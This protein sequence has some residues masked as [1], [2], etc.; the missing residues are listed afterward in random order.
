[1]AQAASQSE[2]VACRSELNSTWRKPSKPS[3][4]LVK[5][6]AGKTWRCPLKLAGRISCHCA[7]EFP[8]KAAL[9]VVCAIIVS[10]AGLTGRRVDIE[11]VSAEPAILDK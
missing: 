11:S 7:L 2:L 9:E 8:A 3:L 4:L 6:F 5:P 10:P 1:M